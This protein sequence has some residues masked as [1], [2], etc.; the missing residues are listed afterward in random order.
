ITTTKSSG[1]T[2]SD[3]GIDSTGSILLAVGSVLD[4]SSGGYISSQGKPKMASPGV[5]AGRGGA[6]TLRLDQGHD[7]DVQGAT[8]PLRPTSGPV[9]HLELDGILHAYGF[10]SNGTLTLGAP[11][12]IRIGG[13]PLTPGDG[14][15]L[16][17]SLFTSGGF[18]SYVLEST[19]DGWSGVTTSITVSAGVNLTLQQQN[20]S[21]LVDYSA[22]PTGAKITTTAP[23]ATL[24]D[25]QRAP[26]NLALKSE[27]I[28]L[29]AGA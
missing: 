20:L 28:L 10:E 21:S 1:A 2:G 18:G 13:A 8:G 9:A 27:Q 19:P 22:V 7:Y 12:A 24:P 23:P 11:K 17:A 14:L 26:V 29:D 4:V 25:S 15:Y 3:G 16:P 6:I 5:M